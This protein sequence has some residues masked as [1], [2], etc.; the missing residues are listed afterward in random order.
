MIPRVNVPRIDPGHDRTMVN[1][2]FEYGLDP[3]FGDVFEYMR[4][5]ISHDLSSL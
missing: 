4:T 5:A 2:T 1:Q 3:G